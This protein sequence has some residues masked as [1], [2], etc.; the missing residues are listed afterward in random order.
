MLKNR[1]DVQWYT[2]ASMRL[3]PRSARTVCVCVHVLEHRDIPVFLELLTILWAWEYLPCSGYLILSVM[4]RLASYCAHRHDSLNK[5]NQF[6][7]FTCALWAGAIAAPELVEIQAHT[8]GHANIYDCHG[9]FRTISCSYCCCLL[10]VHKSLQL[11]KNISS[12][13]DVAPRT[14]HS[15]RYIISLWMR[16]DWD[17][18]IVLPLLMSLWKQFLQ[19][20]YPL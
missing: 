8:K 6:F 15:M 7:F 14:S 16:W 9:H 13:R 18:E 19:S 12:S 4:E 20:S 10:M 11:K 5:T 1:S 3:T 2:Q 17:E